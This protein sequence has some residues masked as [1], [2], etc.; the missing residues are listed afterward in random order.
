MAGMLA[1]TTLMAVLFGILRSFNAHPA[2]YIFLGLL[3]LVTCLVQMRYGELPRVAS[4]LAGVLVMFLCALGLFLFGVYFD[5]RFDLD[6]IGW[7][8]FA[9]PILAGFGA[10]FGYL[11]GT[12]TA[13]LFLLMDMLESSLSGGGTGGLRYAQPRK[14]G[15][16]EPV[17]AELVPADNDMIHA[18]LAENPFVPVRSHEP[19]PDKPDK[20]AEPFDA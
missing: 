10:F 18:L 11:S 14:A 17:M 12:C 13:G 9:S 16:P 8:V 4:M 1:I 19:A 20:P 5:R 2:A 6:D 15:R 3:A 7:L